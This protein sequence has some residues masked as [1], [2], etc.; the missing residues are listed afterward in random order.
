MSRLRTPA[1]PLSVAPIILCGTVVSSCSQGLTAA[2]WSVPAA[3][4]R[5]PATVGYHQLYPFKG[6]TDGRSP[7]GAFIE[8]GGVWYGTTFGGQRFHGTVFAFTPSGG[9]HVLHLFQHG[10]SD[11]KRRTR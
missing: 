8:G 11:G 5:G 10:K 6:G 3:A 2:G 4:D 9:E 1:W 7:T